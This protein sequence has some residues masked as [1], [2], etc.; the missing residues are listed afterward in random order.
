MSVLEVVEYPHP[1]L[2]FKCRPLK[3]VNA[4]IKAVIEEMTG[5]MHTEKGN[6]LAA[7]QV[8]LP[9]RLI[10]VTY[11]KK[12]FAFINPVIDFVPKTK[13]VNGREG[14]LSLIDLYLPILRK[15]KIRFRA[16]TPEGN[17]IDEIIEGDLARIL[18]HEVDHLDGTLIIDKIAGKPRLQK[19]VE[20]Y[21]ELCARAYLQNPPSINGAALD[22]LMEEYCL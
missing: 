22:E 2:R 4:S 16:W 19:E 1:M 14:C 18:Q 21:L 12:D 17:D 7:P 20:T 11:D 13:M 6:G 3:R 10:T 8:G 5:V 15:K 9:F